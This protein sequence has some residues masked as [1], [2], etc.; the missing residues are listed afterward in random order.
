VAAEGTVF[1]RGRLRLD[2]CPQGHAQSQVSDRELLEAEQRFPLNPP[3][4]KEQYLYR[5]LF[6]RHFPSPSAAATVPGGPSIACSTPE[7]LA[8]DE[9]FAAMADPSGRAMRGVHRDSY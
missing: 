1:R 5:R 4:T 9:G 8:W 2:R 7:A 3:I 6:E